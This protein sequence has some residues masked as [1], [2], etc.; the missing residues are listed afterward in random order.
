MPV[1]LRGKHQSTWNL[2]HKCEWLSNAHRLNVVFWPM[3]LR[4]PK[5]N[6]L[7]AIFRASKFN[8]SEAQ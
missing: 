2:N 4:T 5:S 6:K 7:V 8:P 1:L 3:S